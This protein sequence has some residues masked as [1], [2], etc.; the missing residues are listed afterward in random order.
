MK[1][2]KE[3]A[4]GAVIPITQLVLNNACPICERTFSGRDTAVKH[5]KIYVERGK[6][7][8]AKTEVWPAKM[9]EI[10]RGKCTCPECEEQWRT[11]KAALTHMKIHI[12]ELAGKG[13]G[14][15]MTDVGGR[16]IETAKATQED[17]RKK[18]KAIQ[19]EKKGHTKYKKEQIRKA[20]RR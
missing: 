17:W 10:P 2:H 8:R 19:E 7:P 6:C 9:K 15:D 18:K 16:K 1:N 14:I 3:K 13:T 11:T 20:T 4:H 5:V 12:E